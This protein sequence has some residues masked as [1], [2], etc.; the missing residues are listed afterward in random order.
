M[1]LFEVMPKLKKIKVHF[2]NVFDIL[3]VSSRRVMHSMGI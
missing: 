3:I 2:F 1:E